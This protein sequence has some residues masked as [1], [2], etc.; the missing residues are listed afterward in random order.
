MS[1]KVFAKIKWL[2]MQKYKPE[3]AMSE[4][5]GPSCF[6]MWNEMYRDWTEEDKIKLF[7]IYY[8][9]DL[10][11]Y[12]RQTEIQLE[13]EKDMKQLT[14][15]KKSKYFFVTVG[16]D[17][18]TITVPKIKKFRESVLKMAGVKFHSHVVEKFRRNDKGDIYEHHHMHFLIETDYYKA[19]V[20]QYFYT[21]ATNKLNTVVAAKS[22]IDVKNDASFEV[23][24]KYISGEKKQEKMACV[25]MDKKW[26]L[27][28]EI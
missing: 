26:R 18:K 19:K 10:A 6:N 1:D 27:E 24:E 4:V 17:D 13:V 25:E 9:I 21:K 22:F 8:R 12:S 14:G 15:A 20:V 2:H 3:Y 16:F 7:E 23:Y 28:N 11:F 5:T